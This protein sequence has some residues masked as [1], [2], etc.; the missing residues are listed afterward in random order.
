M[1]ISRVHNKLKI[2]ILKLKYTY[3]KNRLAEM[4]AHPDPIRKSIEFRKYSYIKI[5]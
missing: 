5:Y 3:K 2:L 1:H 4:N